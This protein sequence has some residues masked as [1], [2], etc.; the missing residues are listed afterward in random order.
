MIKFVFLIIFCLFLPGKAD[1]L[2]PGG[3]GQETFTLAKAVK[4]GRGASHF[5]GASSH[6][7]NGTAG[8]I[9]CTPFSCPAGQYFKEDSCSCA[10]CPGGEDC[11]CEASY[12][13]NSVSNGSGSCGCP[14]GF[15]F[16]P[17]PGNKRDYTA[18]KAV[19]CAEGEDCDCSYHYGTGSVSD[20]N[21]GCRTNV[22]CPVGQ[23]LSY[24]GEGCLACPELAVCN[25][26]FSWQEYFV[27]IGSYCGNAD[28]TICN[29]PTFIC[30]DGY[31][32]SSG[33]FCAECRKE[34][35]SCTGKKCL[36]CKSGFQLDPVSGYCGVSSP[37][38][39]NCLMCTDSEHCLTCAAGYSMSYGQCIK[40]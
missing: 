34:C 4:L 17:P 26:R 30:N 18:C 33:S 24:F 25:G 31:Y 36:T 27:S 6:P 20:G 1:A 8:K 15:T 10:F 28:K 40:R 11:G 3:S 7:D 23:Y 2:F 12:G 13:G 37:C 32:L 35:A 38:P 14:A 16:T 29:G 21:G 39:A 5:S 19:P 9:S 22:A